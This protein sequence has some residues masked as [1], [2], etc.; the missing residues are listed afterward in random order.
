MRAAPA[1]QKRRQVPH[2]LKD[3]RALFP[4][5]RDSELIEDGGCVVLIARKLGVAP[6]TATA[7]PQALARA[8]LVTATRIGQRTFGR[9]DEA[10]PADLRNEIAEEL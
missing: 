8:G 4:P 3:P 10:A 2:R 1:S 5:R 6:P 7:H 9:R